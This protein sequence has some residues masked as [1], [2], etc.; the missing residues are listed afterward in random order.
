MNSRESKGKG[1]R[2]LYTAG[3]LL[4][5]V[6]I[7]LYSAGVFSLGKIGPGSEPAAPPAAAAG[8][9]LLRAELV[10]VPEYYEAVGTLRPL[11]EATVEAQVP[12]RV[13]KVLARA[14]QAVEKGQ[15]LVQLDDQQFQARLAQA[16]QGLA[17][18]RA[19]YERAEAEYQRVRGFAQAEAATPQ[20][21]EQ[22]KAGFLGAEAGLRQAQ[23]M[24]QEAEVALGYTRLAAP[25]S[26]QVV[27]R[28]A[29]PGDLALP[30]KPLISV[31]TIGGLRLE[32]LVREGLIARIKPGQRL[33]VEVPSLAP[34]LWGQVEEVAPAADPATRSFLVKV[35]LE[36]GAPGLHA[37]MFGRLLLPLEE[38][39]AVLVPRQ[40]L[41]RVGQLE[42]VRV[43]TAQGWQSVYVTTGRQVD[44]RVEV[45]SGLKGDETLAAEGGGDES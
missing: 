20:N 35:G 36:G 8:E 37:G 39:P 22:A 4:A 31:Q 23:Q 32:A 24:V 9:G 2:W 44:G 26:G 10:R 14:G 42:M 34:G 18:A 12:G 43:R 29:E 41:R 25:A 30:G 33:K 17:A 19:N 21:L 16:R 45:L 13:L 11:S 38:R 5:L 15:L 1:P 3:G 27:K 28:L 40:A 6:L 7:V